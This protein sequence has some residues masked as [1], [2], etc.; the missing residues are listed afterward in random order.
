MKISFKIKT[1][2][3]KIKKINPKTFQIIKTNKFSKKK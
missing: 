1:I 2:I 3:S